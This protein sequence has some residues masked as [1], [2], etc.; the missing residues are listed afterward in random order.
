MNLAAD[1]GFPYN[2]SADVERDKGVI[3]SSSYAVI[4]MM[5]FRLDLCYINYNKHKN[6]LG[7]TT[8]QHDLL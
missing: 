4:D 8:N 1:F 7:W 5:S 3:V 2:E 6:Q